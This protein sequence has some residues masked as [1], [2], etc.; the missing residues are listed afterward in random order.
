MRKE[1]KI[2]IFTIITVAL[3]IWGYKYLRGFNILSQK[4]TLYAVYD[5]VDGVTISTPVYI[6]GLEVGLVAEFSQKA[7]DLNKI[8]VE[9]QINRDIKIPKT[10]VAEIVTTSLMGGTAINLVFEGTCSGDG[11]VKSGDT[12]EGVTKGMLASFATPEEVGVYVE[13]LN[14]GLRGVLDTLSMRLSESEELSQSVQDV[15]A[16]LTNL[17]STTNR[18]D[19]VMARSSG[20]IE[21]SLKNIE[22]I[23]GT[24]KASNEQIKT[25]LANAE[26][27]ST[28]LKDADMKAL[29]GETK[30]TMQ[31]LQSTLSSS[32][33][34]IADLSALLQSLKSGDGTV[35]MLLNDKEFAG[36]L[37]LTVKNLDLL[38]RDIRLHPERYRRILSKK[39][40]EYKL[41]PLE[42][43]PAHKN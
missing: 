14:E 26:A 10:A 25:I 18:L 24:L 35:A 4:T 28:D 30:L 23:T 15:R 6:H 29:V 22:A 9:M 21:G 32:D 2:A 31:K 17:K 37:E 40:M 38:L 20:S 42:N 11:C 41:T 7:E 27:V 12:I 19:G 16:I 3:A 43:D 8:V 39:E 36:N 5:R 33:K 13:V 34:A 1:T